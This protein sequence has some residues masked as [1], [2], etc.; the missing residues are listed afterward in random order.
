MRVRILDVVIIAASAALVA[1]SAARA[2]DPGSGEPR[3]V[4]SGPGGEWV[5]P[6]DEARELRVSGPLGDTI[7]DIGA[8]SARIVDSP[9]PNKTCIASGA[10][11]RPGQWAACLPNKVIVRVE[12]ARADGGVDAA[13]Y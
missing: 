3:A 11:S 12:G 5:Y 4:V 7:I 2:Y 6:L 1:A 10:L 9:C 8:G 13:A